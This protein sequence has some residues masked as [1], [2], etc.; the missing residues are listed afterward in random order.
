MKTICSCDVVVGNGYV[1]VTGAY[2]QINTTG[3]SCDVVVGNVYVAVTIG[4]C[5]QINTN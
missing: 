3:C 1:A 5:I 4:V 2:I